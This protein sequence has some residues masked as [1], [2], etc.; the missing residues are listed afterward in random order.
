MENKEESKKLVVS[1]E[2][3]EQ[4]RFKI[5]KYK[6]YDEYVAHQKSKLPIITWM[7]KY[8]VDYRKALNERLEKLGMDFKGKNVLCLAARIGTEVKSFCDQGAFA[9]GID[10]NPGEEN[11]YVVHGDFH[12]I[13]FPDNSADFVFSNSFDHTLEPEKMISEIKRILKKDGT[14][15]ME[16]GRP[17][18]AGSYECLSWERIDDVIKLFSS[19]GFTLLKRSEYNKGGLLPGGEQLILKY[20]K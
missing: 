18:P 9:I 12:D 8:D 6:N 15:I 4:N 5:R 20:G 1:K 16:I 2:F 3:I 17:G 19:R 11:K 10:L 7:D 14:L 13:Q